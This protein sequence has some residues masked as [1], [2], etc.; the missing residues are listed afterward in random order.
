ME[1]KWNK[2]MT[3]DLKIGFGGISNKDIITSNKDR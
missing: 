3:V 2:Y 1:I